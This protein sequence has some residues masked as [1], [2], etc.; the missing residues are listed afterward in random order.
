MAEAFR[1]QKRLLEEK[2]T[3]L[4]R[5]IRTIE[6]A[7]IGSD[8]L[9]RSAVLKGI[10]EAIEM[11]TNQDWI[12]KYATE[13]GGPKIEARK[14]LWSS[15]LQERVSRQWN[16]LISD[17]EHAVGD[18]PTSETAQALAARWNSLVE[19]FTGRDR[20]IEESVGNMWADRSNWPVDMNEKAP[21]IKKEVWEFIARANAA[22][23]YSSK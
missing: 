18:D 11:D 14:Q 17:V 3:V 21:V 22:G 23:G 20:D 5:V 16:D 13:R 12:T 7:E 10:I 6:D 1:A 9:N 2:R 8:G 15:E 19:E 4:N